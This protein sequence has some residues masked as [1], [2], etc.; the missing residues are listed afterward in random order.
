MLEKR[1]ILEL[2]LQVQARLIAYRA[3]NIHSKQIQPL[4]DWHVKVLEVRYEG[5][6]SMH[7]TV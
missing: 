1:G 7:C 4:S 6:P 5:L 2:G 3:P